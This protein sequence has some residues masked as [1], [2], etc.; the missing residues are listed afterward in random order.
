MRPRV[1][2]VHQQLVA[3]GGSEVCAMWTLQGLA[4]EYRVTLITM[5][6][7]DLGALSRSCGTTVDE[8][9]IEVRA[10][11]ILPG[12]RKRFDAL[13]GGPLD[14][15]CRR[16]ARDF[17]VMI[18]AYNTMDFG[19]PGIQLV[20]DFSFDDD[21]RREVHAEAGASGGVLYAASA[22]R[23]L[24]L[25]LARALAG[26][27]RDGWMENRTLAVSEWVRGLLKDRFGVDSTVLYPPVSVDVPQVPWDEREDGFVVMGRLVPEKGIPQVIEI[28]SEVRKVKP[29]H[30]HVIS[31]PTR[32]AY[33]REIERL[34]RANAG[35]IRFEGEVYGRDKG[36]LLAGHKYGISGCRA[37]SFG[38]AVAEMAKA[39]EIVWVPDGGGQTEVV[40]D[41]ALIYAG[42]DDAVSR[43]VKVITDAER[44]TA[45]RR[46]LEARAAAF[47]SSRFVS[48]MRSAVRDFLGEGRVHG[49]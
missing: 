9:R 24:Y 6:R 12:L 23:S 44:E 17:D 11:P 29:V 49:A 8:S 42:R 26:R 4:D 34:C 3:G 48:G 46:H 7:P 47:S 13:R 1:A 35:W 20:A 21:L 19:V 15:H 43:I 30:L 33:A 27:S 45:L 18:S 28:L 16:H 36:A 40:T 39:G 5:G 41:A 22:G 38:I 37:E 25:S 14:R 2:V 31:R 10:L 32:A